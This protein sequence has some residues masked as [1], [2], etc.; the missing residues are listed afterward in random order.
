MKIGFIGLGKMGANMAER[1]LRTG[2]KDIFQKLELIFK[3]LAPEDGYARVGPSGADLAFM[4][5]F[6]SRQKESFSAK[7]IAALRNEFGGHAV[8]KTK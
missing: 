6:R 2:E 4:E 7:F 1:L 8:K 5:R 3:A